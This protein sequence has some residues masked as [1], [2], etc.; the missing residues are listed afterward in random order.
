MKL[1]YATS[2]RLE[3]FLINLDMVEFIEECRDYNVIHL[4]SKEILLVKESL[5]FFYAFNK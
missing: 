4:L 1:I 3:K 2:F 5:E